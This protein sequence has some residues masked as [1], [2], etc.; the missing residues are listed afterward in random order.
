MYVCV[1]CIETYVSCSFSLSPPHAPRKIPGQRDA[2]RVHEGK[3]E[4]LAPSFWSPFDLGMN[5]LGLVRRFPKSGFRIH[6]LRLRE[7][8]LWDLGHWRQ[9]FVF[10]LSVCPR[11]TVE[12]KET[13]DHLPKTE[14]ASVREAS[15]QQEGGKHHLKGDPNFNSRHPP[16]FSENNMATGQPPRKNNV[17]KHAN[18]R[19]S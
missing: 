2:R 4:S 14:G 17:G 9:A 3:A 15:A 11:L 19:P 18:R 5:L 10:R 1:L 7:A 13:K 12:L 8:P 16:Y 6:R